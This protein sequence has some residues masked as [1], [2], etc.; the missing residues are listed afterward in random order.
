MKRSLSFFQSS[1]YCCISANWRLYCSNLFFKSFLSPLS[2][3]TSL[4]VLSCPRWCSLFNFSWSDSDYQT[5]KTPPPNWWAFNEDSWKDVTWCESVD[6]SELGLSNFCNNF[7]FATLF[8]LNSFDS[9]AIFSSLICSAS[10]V[11]CC[12]VSNWLLS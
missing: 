10:F 6:I 1:E 3:S 8:S 4:S 11:C 9:L 5:Y 2:C 12:V 7:C